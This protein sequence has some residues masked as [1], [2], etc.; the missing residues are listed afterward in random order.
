MIQVLIGNKGEGKTKQLI[1]RANESVKGSKGHI[2]FIDDSNRHIYELNHKI[3]FINTT[4]FPMKNENEFYGFV[5]G[6]MSE[7]HD[8]EEIYLDGLLKLAQTDIHTAQNLIQ[9]LTKLSERYNVKFII[10]ITCE[11]KTI[12][13]DLK[14]YFVA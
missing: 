10:S 1:D 7:D 6:I 3:R 8:I 4:D 14:V 13:D 5:C 11:T 9:K 12:P 2:V